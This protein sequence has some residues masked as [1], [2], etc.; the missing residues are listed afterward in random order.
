MTTPIL[1]VADDLTGALDSAVPFAA[2]G[3]HVRVALGV[4]AIG[5]AVAAAPD[6]LAIDTR[7]RL[8]PAPRAAE[9]VEAAWAAASALTPRLVMKKIDSRLKG[10]LAGETAALLAASGRRVAIACPAVPEQG[11]GVSGGRLTGR[12]V[13]APIVVAD[14]FG[15][16]PCACPDA[17]ADADLEI[18]ARSI[19]DAPD[20]VL[21][22][23]ARGLAS[24]LARLVGGPPKAE[25]ATAPALPMILAIGSRDP[26]TGAQIERL[27]LDCPQVEEIAA[28]A[29]C[30]GDFRDPVV[31]LFRAPSRNDSDP[32]AVAARFG[33]E[34]AALVRASSAKTVLCS[35]GDTAAAV[36]DAIDARQLVP[37]YE[38]AP[39]VPVARIEGAGGVRL[40]TKSGGFGDPG[41]LSRIVRQAVAGIRQAAA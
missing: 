39:G 22:V 6:V 35:G 37:E 13:I 7:S 32:A 40:I 3:L 15:G 2:R 41:V 12:G 20:R 28:S 31:L 23:G 11:R 19:L 38:L 24:A 9:H 30:P 36:M 29:P 21:A 8:L 27:R 1:I 18:L 25:N 34:A 4:D 33:R 10:N 14:H 17:A 16:L 26:I 5:E